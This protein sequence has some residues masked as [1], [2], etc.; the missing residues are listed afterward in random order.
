VVTPP[1]SG[2]GK[3]TAKHKPDGPYLN[4][5]IDGK[6]FGTTP[7]FNKTIPAGTHTIELLE[8]DT[9][10]VVV[11]KTVTVEPGQSVKIEP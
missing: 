6:L 9:A 11:R 5:V 4:V 8:P 7:L 3:L 2:V 10:K 1:L